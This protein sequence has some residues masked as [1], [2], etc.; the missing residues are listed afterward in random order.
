MEPRTH[1]SLYFNMPIDKLDVGS[2]TYSQVAILNIC[3]FALSFFSSFFHAPLINNYFDHKIFNCFDRLILTD[4]DWQCLK[5][6]IQL[7]DA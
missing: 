7:K 6:K 4:G 2:A 5:I 3:P 1:S